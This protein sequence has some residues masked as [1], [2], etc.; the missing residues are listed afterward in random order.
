MNR[1]GDDVWGRGLGEDDE[2][3]DAL[4]VLRQVL[5]SEPPEEAVEI[6]R[7]LF[8]DRV[9]MAPGIVTPLRDAPEAMLPFVLEHVNWSGVVKAIL[10]GGGRDLGQD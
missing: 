2:D 7:C 6:V 9:R 4:A 1:L 3:R 5:R 10:A 8:T